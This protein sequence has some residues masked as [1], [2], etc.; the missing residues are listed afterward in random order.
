MEVNRHQCYFFQT[1]LLQHLKYVKVNSE[2]MVRTGE[3]WC[4]ENINTK[5]NFLIYLPAVT[6]LLE[7]FW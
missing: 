4:F 1:G 2:K 5:Y 7:E 3:N 6:K